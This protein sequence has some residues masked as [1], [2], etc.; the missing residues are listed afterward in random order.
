MKINLRQAE[1]KDI[2]SKDEIDDEFVIEEFNYNIDK[3]ESS[4][5]SIDTDLAKK[6]ERVLS[7]A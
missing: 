3:H 1:E 5:Y 4:S 2:Q 7:D 6:Q